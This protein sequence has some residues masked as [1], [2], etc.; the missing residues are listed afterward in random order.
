MDVTVLCYHAVDA[1]WT[2][3][4]SV[5]PEELANQCA[6]LARHRTVL[7]LH[8][9]VRRLDASG[10][11]P[12]GEVAIT[13]DDG[14]VD[15][16][17]HAA[18][19]LAGHG[20]PMTVFLVAQTLTDEG[21]SVNW[22]R[23]APEWPLITLT[24]D[25]VHEMQDLGVDFQSHSWAHKDLPEL[26][27]DDCLHD[28]RTSKE[29]LEDLLR[30]EVPFLAY[31]RGLHDENVRRAAERAGYTHA[32]ALPEAPEPPGPYAVPRVGIH[33]GNGSAVLAAKASRAYLPVRNGPV[34]DVARKARRL[35]GRVR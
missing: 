19:L 26:G 15:N 28:L 4:L 9:A 17:T 24:V 25:Q 2:S 12:R 30:H 33:R 16:L 34:G 18:P 29:F 13:F 35:L 22:V 1:A 31:P 5:R 11:L 6:W 23:T 3:P 27:F 14:F 20:F 21:L 32:F 8:E 10:R 7:P